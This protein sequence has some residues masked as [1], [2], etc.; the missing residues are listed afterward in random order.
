ML[1]FGKAVKKHALVMGF[2]MG[3]LP[4]PY[5]LDFLEIGSLCLGCR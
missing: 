4:A 1:S 2:L 3:L 5:L